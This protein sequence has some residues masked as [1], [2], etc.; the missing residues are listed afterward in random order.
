MNSNYFQF[1]QKLMVSQ[2]LAWCSATIII[3]KA[4]YSICTSEGILDKFNSGSAL[5]VVINGCRYELIP[6]VK[7]EDHVETDD[8][9]KLMEEAMSDAKPYASEVKVPLVGKAFTN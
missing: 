9:A 8:I 7:V 3:L 6:E 2:I 4:G 5:D 1:M